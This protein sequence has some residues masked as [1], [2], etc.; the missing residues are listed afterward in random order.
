MNNKFYS[1]ISVIGGGAWGTA[2]ASTLTKNQDCINLWAKELEVVNS[3]NTK[4]ENNLFLPGI[5]LS[6]K[7]KAH[8][9]FKFIDM[10]DL[11]FFV[12]PAQYFRKTLKDISNKIDKNVP[13][14]LCS[15]GVE[16]KTLN[17][18]SEIANNILPDNPIAVLSG[19]S[20]AIDV[21][22]NLPTALTLAC[23]ADDVGGKIAETINS[24]EFRIYQS[25]D[26]IGAQ[27]G[28]A[29]KNIIAIASGIV[30]GKGLGDS[31]RSALIARGYSEIVQLAKAMGGKEKTLTGLSG[32][33]DLI[34]T[35]NSQTS[36]NFT[37]GVKLGRGMNINEATNG[38]TSIAEGMFSTKA[39]VKLAKIHNVIMPITDSI[40]KLIDNESDIDTIIEELLSRPLKEES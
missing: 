33:G 20:F 29:T 17:L 34:L 23:D 1:S 36:R 39:I 32:M 3:I 28:G 38:L 2:I 7:I 31:A 35:C 6:K 14:V 18:M 30:Y 22:N 11:L 26:I 27:I 13:I 25:R 40:N 24:A 37:L 21:A 4:N 10:S 5:S 9:D 12:T 19:P 8:N 16:I 15:K